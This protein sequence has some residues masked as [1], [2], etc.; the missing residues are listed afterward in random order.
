MSELLDR[1]LSYTAIDTESVPDVE[2]FPSSEKQKDLLRLL[3]NQLA[4][5]VGT[6]IAAPGA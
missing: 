6:G 2:Q 5:T 1:F 3:A 4:D